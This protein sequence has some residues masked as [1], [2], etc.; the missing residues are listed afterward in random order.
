MELLLHVHARFLR[1]SGDPVHGNH[2]HVRLYDQD[3]T[4]DDFLSEEQPDKEG[5]VHF[6]INPAQYK[7]IDSP[8]EKKPDLYM[9]L[10]H[11]GKE[12][13]RTP[14]IQDIDP[15]TETNFDETEGEW[16]DMGSFLI[17]E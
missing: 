13:F 11:D 2:Y 15:D 9:V 4:E 1:H 12:I 17:H 10:Y 16:V 6:T 8:G 3:I 14:V 7:S 5:K